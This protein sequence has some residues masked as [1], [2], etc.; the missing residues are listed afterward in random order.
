[1]RPWASTGTTSCSEWDSGAHDWVPTGEWT[2]NSKGALKALEML[3]RMLPE[4]GGGKDDSAPAG[5][6]ALLLGGGEMGGREF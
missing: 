6:E 4:V 5:L 2:Y 3:W 1:M